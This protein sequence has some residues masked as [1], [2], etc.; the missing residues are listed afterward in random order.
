L[1][2][3]AA[4]GDEPGENVL[5]TLRGETPATA[6]RGIIDIE[7]PEEPCGVGLPLGDDQQCPWFRDAPLADV[8]D[9]VQ[10]ALRAR[11]AALGDH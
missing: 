8:L 10:F 7:M 3:N 1:P 11:L 4:R 5:D 6:T 2:P 9:E